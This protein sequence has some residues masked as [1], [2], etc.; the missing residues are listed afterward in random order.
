MPVVVKDPGPF[1]PL[2]E[3]PPGTN[4]IVCIGGRGGRK[5]YEVS[6]FIAYS[7]AVKKKRAVILRDEKAL[8]KET[9]LNEIW[10]RYDTANANGRLDLE[11]QKN[12]TELKDK[13][14]G[15][16]LLYTK[17]FRAT[18]LEKTAN[19]K[20]PSDI[21]IAIIEE[22]E[23]IRS[24]EMF[25]T[26][27]DGLRKEGC[28]VIIMLNT[29][30]L[31][32]FICKRLFHATPVLDERGEASGYFTLTPRTDIPGF[33][34]IQTSFEDNP[35]LPAH[36]VDRYKGYG[37]PKHHLFDLHH[38]FTAIKGYASSGRKGQIL[39]KVKTISRQEYYELPFTEYYG[40]DFGTA[41]PAAMVGVKFD[42]NT[43]WIRLINYKPMPALELGKLYS[44]LKLGA[45]DKIVCDSAEAT[46]SIVKLANGWHD[47]DASLYEKYPELNRGFFAVPCPKKDISG[48]LGLMISMELYAIE[49]DTDLWEEIN[50]YCYAQDKYGNYT[51]DPIDD[52]NHAIDAARYI[53]SDQRGLEILRAY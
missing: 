25:D 28:I 27:V 3:P 8:I 34:C 7:C 26:F 29:P 44:T 23:D 41:S 5:T 20:G 22:G 15:K 48:H 24:K 4:L 45:A 13:K 43:A 36:I 39:T 53:I 21:D 42:G 49:E 10:T 31:A 16:T 2:Y 32:H 47:L 9:I 52:F 50:N 1:K 33:L 30:S 11:C 19:M 18:T 51:D 37:D 17:G 12:E 14:T 35:F 46:T 6:K 40:Q 38:Y